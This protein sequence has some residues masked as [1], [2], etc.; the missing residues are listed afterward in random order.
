[1]ELVRLDSPHRIL[2]NRY[3]HTA[4]MS[5]LSYFS[6]LRIKYTIFMKVLR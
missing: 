3:E 2:L 4:V 1:M 5:K 6:T